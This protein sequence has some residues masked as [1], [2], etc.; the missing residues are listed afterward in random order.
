MAGGSWLEFERA[1][2]AGECPRKRNRLQGSARL[3]EDGPFFAYLTA[4]EEWSV[5]GTGPVRLGELRIDRSGVDTV[6]VRLE[7]AVPE[8]HPGRYTVVYCNDPCTKGLGDLM[9]G[10]FTVLPVLS[11]TGLN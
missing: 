3:V 7:F 9:G 1:H 11:S 4:K 10:W 6:R 5:P 2:S 8:V